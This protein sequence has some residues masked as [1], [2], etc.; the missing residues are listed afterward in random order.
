MLPTRN[1]APEHEPIV[2]SDA[3]T[4][5][6]PFNSRPVVRRLFLLSGG[7]KSDEAQ[8]QVASAQAPS[9]KAASAELPR[10]RGDAAD[11]KETVSREDA[12]RSIASEMPPA[13]GS[14]PA[15]PAARVAS[16]LPPTLGGSASK[17]L[18]RPSPPPKSPLATAPPAATTP[19]AVTPPAAKTP[20]AVTPPA[21]IAQTPRVSPFK[22]VSPAQRSPLAIAQERLAA[23]LA[24]VGDPPGG[25]SPA[26]ADS[27]PPVSPETI[28]ASDL[29]A[30][31][32]LIDLPLVDLPPSDTSPSK[33]P[34]SEALTPAVPPE[35]AAI[36]R[37]T[38]DEAPLWRPPAVRQP[39]TAPL[40]DLAAEESSADPA[41][42]DV[43]PPPAQ[44]QEANGL[45][46]LPEDLGP[47][48]AAAPPAVEVPAAP[49][50]LADVGPRDSQVDRVRRP[51]QSVLAAPQ[52]LTVNRPEIVSPLA[53]SD[54]S[55]PSPE[56]ADDDH[57]LTAEAQKATVVGP[58]P[59][60]VDRFPAPNFLAPP[61]LLL[62]ENPESNALQFL[63]LLNGRQ[64]ELEPGERRLFVGGPNW[65][66]TFD[67]GGDFGSAHNVLDEGAYRFRVAPEGWGI[68]RTPS[69]GPSEP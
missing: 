28:Q 47:D 19:P 48:D 60:A 11:R 21:E 53:S 37:P 56:P 41:S 51:E 18:W 52:P 58:S 61:G 6:R 59:L 66:L 24:V 46:V 16:E 54:A 1:K 25:D 10:Q 3:A 55:R 44:A 34:A 69:V 26:P 49:E 8:K 57:A 63:F 30:A 35:I 23:G 14:R 4:F 43:P 36:P 42:A 9:S 39:E 40:G 15:A 62:L 27:T 32:P 29:V 68:F 45:A 38:G 12:Q 2:A 31:T 67:R 13:L 64:H 33:T 22:E 5:R 65:T 17:E 20:P 7:E 50:A